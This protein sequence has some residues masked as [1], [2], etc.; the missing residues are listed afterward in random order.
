MVPPD[1]IPAQHPA[2]AALEAAP[3]D[4]EPITDGEEALVQEARDA[5]LEG[6]VIS[7][8]EFRRRFGL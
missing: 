5:V 8:D 7:D 4:D 6:R 1:S 2:L 3:L